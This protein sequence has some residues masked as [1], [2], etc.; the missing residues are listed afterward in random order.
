MMP[1]HC[2]TVM[3]NLADTATTPNKNNERVDNMA[4]LTWTL[5]GIDAAPQEQVLA[6]IGLLEHEDDGAVDP[7]CD[8]GLRWPHGRRGGGRRFI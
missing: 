1:Q 3:T 8:A 6:V 4:S 5:G 7:V 2:Q